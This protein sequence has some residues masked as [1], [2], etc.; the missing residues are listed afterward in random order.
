MGY[1]DSKKHGPYPGQKATS[2]NFAHGVGGKSIFESGPCAKFC[3][4]H[5]MKLNKGE[6]RLR[7]NDKSEALFSQTVTI[8]GKGQ[9]T[10]STN[11]SSPTSSPVES[12]TPPVDKKKLANGVLETQPEYQK[13]LPKTL[14]DVARVLRSKNSGPYEI[15]F[16]VMFETEGEYRLVKNANIL[17]RDVVAK[18][19]EVREEDI[20]W[21]GFFDQ[22]RAFK[23]TIPRM[24][25][26]KSVSGGSFMESDMHGAQKY[27][28]LFNM[29]LSERFIQAWKEEVGMDKK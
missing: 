8:I 17:N 3:M 26:G 28:G 20:I 4:Y 6:E 21:I 14:G 24:W 23:A 2:G 5:L 13:S 1:A 27:L 7:I 18:L 25:R 12:F 16:D 22:A 19:L 11:G 10:P 15:T 9:S 29:K